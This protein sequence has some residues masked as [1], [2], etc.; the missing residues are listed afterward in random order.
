M[1]IIPV[2]LTQQ[3]GVILN[4]VFHTKG[5]I[6]ESVPTPE[7][8]IPGRLTKPTRTPFVR[9]SV[10]GIKPNLVSIKIVAYSIDGRRIGELAR[11]NA[12]DVCVRLGRNHIETSDPKGGTVMDF[13][14]TRK[15]RTF[16]YVSYSFTAWP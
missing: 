7:P 13:P 11:C 12:Q 4:Q 3:V 5:T 1:T 15:H 6:N 10:T 16:K 9:W 14:T 2:T 8:L